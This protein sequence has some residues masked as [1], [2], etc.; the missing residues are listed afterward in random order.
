MKRERLSLSP[1]HNNKINNKKKKKIKSRESALRKGRPARGREML[2]RGK[3][4][5]NS[6]PTPCSFF[7]PGPLASLPLSLP[8]PPASSLPSFSGCSPLIL[9][10]LFD[11][12]QFPSNSWLQQRGRAVDI[13]QAQRWAGLGWA[14]GCWVSPGQG[15]RWHQPAT[16]GWHLTPRL[17]PF[18]F[19]LEK[20][21]LILLHWKCLFV[22]TEITALIFTDNSGQPRTQARI[23]FHQPCF[24]R[25]FGRGEGGS[26]P[27]SFQP[28]CYY[29]R[30][31]CS[32]CF[33]HHCIPLLICPR[34]TKPN[35]PCVTSCQSFTTHRLLPSKTSLPPSLPQS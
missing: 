16:G 32:Y 9:R 4:R 6:H 21:L 8:H 22:L 19:L 30:C 3:V 31:C 28:H 15:A 5:T 20:M 23:P 18:F 27:T 35:L 17:A 2:L 29:W 26:H 11:F 12:K 24:C 33:Y 10:C 25:C 1:C 14:A 7:S 34:E 13:L